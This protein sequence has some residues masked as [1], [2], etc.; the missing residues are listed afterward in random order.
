MRRPR[1]R[2]ARVG[3]A[4]AV[5]DGLVHLLRSAD[6]DV[7]DGRAVLAV[8]RA[9]EEDLVV[10]RA[11]GHERRVMEVVVVRWRRAVC[12]LEGGTSPRVARCQLALPDATT[13]R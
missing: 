6:L 1:G 3:L 13:C 9:L 12:P 4:R 7:R 5:V 2:L 11:V 10:V 8:A